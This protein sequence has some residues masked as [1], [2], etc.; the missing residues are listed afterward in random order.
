MK[1]I[2]PHP[3]PI[4]CDLKQD[5]LLL[6][7]CNFALEYVIWNVYGNYEGRSLWDTSASVPMLIMS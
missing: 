5:V 3:F 6:V 7:L 4:Q 1:P 2:S